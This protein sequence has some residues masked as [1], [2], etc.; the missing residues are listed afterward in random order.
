[1]TDRNKVWSSLATSFCS[2]LEYKNFRWE[3]KKVFCVFSRRTFVDVSLESVWKQPPPANLAYIYAQCKLDAPLALSLLEI[4]A[5]VRVYFARPTIAIAKIR[6]LA[7]VLASKVFLK[8]PSLLISG[9]GG[10]ASEKKN[11]RSTCGQ[12]WVCLYFNYCGFRCW[13]SPVYVLLNTT[14]LPLSR[15]NEVPY[16]SFLFPLVKLLKVDF[17][18]NESLVLIT[19]F[20]L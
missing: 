19:I 6:I 8:S 3:L 18:R 20:E 12:V 5:R 13:F 17:R 7:S 9:S 4:F 14:E 15:S 11:L 1:V 2:A 10:R 16:Y